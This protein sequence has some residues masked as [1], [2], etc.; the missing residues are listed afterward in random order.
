MPVPRGLHDAG[1][2]SIAGVPLQQLRWLSRSEDA[3]V[4]RRVAGRSRTAPG[5]LTRSTAAITSRTELPTPVPRFIAIF[6]PSFV[7]Y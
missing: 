2:V 6:P 4:T 5:P 7:K 1:K 3:R